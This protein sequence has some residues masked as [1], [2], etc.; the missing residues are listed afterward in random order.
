MQVILL[1]PPGSGKGT[2]AARLATQAKALRLTT[3][4]LLRSAVRDGTQLGR[5]AEGY[6]NRGE[7]V[8]DAVMIG[9]IQEQ[10]NRAAV[11]SGFVLDGF[12]RTTAQAEALA[13]MLCQHGGRVEHA[14]LLDV[15]EPEIVARL[16]GRRE[17]AAC[18]AGYHLRFSPPQVVD[19]CDQCGGALI[20]RSD[21]NEA[22][23][24]KRLA[25]YAAATAPLVDFYERQGILRR[26]AGVGGPDLVFAAI[27]SQVS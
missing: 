3:G 26:V 25:V 2:Q 4:E 9:L 10:L 15:P 23:I 11:G 20:Q 16:S 6:M 18:H 1:G 5:S 27:W 21:D 22:T 13:T 17:C 19:K 14:V 24:R 12:P 8:P 7:L